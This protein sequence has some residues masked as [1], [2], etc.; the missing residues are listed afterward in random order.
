[1]K[2]KLLSLARRFFMIPPELLKFVGV[3]QVREKDPHLEFKETLFF[4]LRES[5][6]VDLLHGLLHGFPSFQEGRKMCVDVALIEYEIFGT[7]LI[8]ITINNKMKI[9]I[10]S[11]ISRGRGPP[12]LWKRRKPGKFAYEPGEK[13]TIRKKRGVVIDKPFTRMTDTKN[14]SFIDETC[15]F[16]L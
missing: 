8:H 10:H 3:T 9:R 1:M 15:L 4:G 13:V 16:F 12:P 14:R 11:I 5:P 7:C 6:C 2:K